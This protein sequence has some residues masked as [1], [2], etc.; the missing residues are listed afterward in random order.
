MLNPAKGSKETKMDRNYCSLDKSVKPAI[1]K[2]AT[3]VAKR[4]SIDGAADRSR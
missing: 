3:Q 1:W 2:R 4:Y